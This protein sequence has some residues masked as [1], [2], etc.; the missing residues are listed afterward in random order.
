[1]EKN[2]YTL[3]IESS[4]D[5]T[6]VAVMKNGRNILSNII[7][8]Q[9]DTHKVF[10]G[11]V[12]EIASR[13]HLEMIN[14]GIEKAVAD[15]GLDIGDMDH[16]VVTNGPGLIGALIVGVSAA[17]ALA[18]ALNKPLTGV[19]HI[20]GHIFSNYV[21]HRDLEPPFVCLVV[22][23][24]HTYLLDVRDYMDVEIKGK[25]IDDAA[26]EAYDKVARTLNLPYPGGPEIDRL[27]KKGNPN[28]IEFPR[29]WL[30]KES[31]DFSFSGL[32]TSVLNYVNTKAQKSEEINPADVASS[33]QEALVDVLYGKTLRLLEE[34]GYR[35]ICIA[36]GVAANSRIK[37]RFQTFSDEKSIEFYYPPLSLCTDNAAMIGCAGYY[38]YMSGR[39]DELDLKVY[40]NMNLEGGE[41][42]G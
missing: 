1:M 5:E 42:G 26:G 34:T 7:S 41:I 40:P 21:A 16:I 4:C 37:E 29:V 27:S 35:K 18:Y 36:G 30:D 25:T 28:A 24:G 13:L 8:S 6:S 9:I 33:F 39:V 38:N 32:K 23:G 11:V 3:A 22:S 2:I 10:G 19:N 31:Y 20:S 12:P 15:S 14:Y 17:K